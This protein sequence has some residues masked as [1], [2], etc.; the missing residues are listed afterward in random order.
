M[1]LE[2][3][4]IFEQVWMTVERLEKILIILR[5]INKPSITKARAEVWNEPTSSLN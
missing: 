3:R 2:L 1:I 4:Y 5:N